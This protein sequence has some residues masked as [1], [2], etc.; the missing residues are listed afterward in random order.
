MAGFLPFVLE[1]EISNDEELP[2]RII[3]R[4]TEMLP[5]YEQNFIIRQPDF[6]V[7][8]DGESSYLYVWH[9]RRNNDRP[10]AVTR[11]D[12]DA[13]NIQVDYVTEGRAFFNESGNSFFHIGWETLLMKERK[14]I[15]HAACV[16]TA[17]GGIL[18]T[19]P[20]SIGKST[21]AELWCKYAQAKLL[22]GDRTILGKEEEWQ[23]YGSPYAGSS[24]CYVNEKCIVAA[25]IVLRQ[26]KTCLIR[27]IPKTQAFRS[28][29]AQLTVNSWDDR[30]VN[31]VCDMAMELL[32]EI[33]VYELACVPDKPA[34]EILQKELGGNEQV[35]M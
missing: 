32:A 16:E 6:S 7:Y 25:I 13:R 27:K 14:M 22:N 8:A 9:D 18:F 17:F 19:G 30:Y 35:W 12:W 5:C 4:E 31:S 2:Y 21:Q 24:K 15:L 23:A 1:N 20:S 10:Y 28:I 26:A 3:F 34:V 33:P 11:F 29:F